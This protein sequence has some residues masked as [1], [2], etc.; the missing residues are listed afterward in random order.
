MLV[1]QRNIACEEA[2]SCGVCGW[3]EM[4]HLKG[5]TTKTVWCFT[6]RA[7]LAT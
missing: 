6:F 1:T 2:L 3:G 5:Q 7:A 4:M